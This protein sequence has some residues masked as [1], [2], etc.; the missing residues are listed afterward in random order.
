MVITYLTQLYGPLKAIG[1]K[2][3]GLQPF[4][5]SING[6]LSCWMKPLMWLNGPTLA[7]SNALLVPLS[8][9]MLAS[10]MT[11]NIDFGWGFIYDGGW[12]AS[13]DCGQNR[14]WEEHADEFADALL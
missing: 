10:P 3:I 13:G 6:P 14:S 9:V 8:F 1:D 11:A 4:R 2:I 5:A 7:H 12:D